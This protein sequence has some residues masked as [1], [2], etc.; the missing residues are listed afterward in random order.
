MGATAAGITLGVAASMTGTSLPR[1]LQLPDVSG[2]PSRVLVVM[3]VPYATD[4]LYHDWLTG[5]Q[6]DH[7]E[8][9]YLTAVSRQINQ[10]S[11]V[12]AIRFASAAASRAPGTLSSS[13][14]I[15][16]AEK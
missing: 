6:Q 11:T 2:M 7:P 15:L 5:L 16:V 8:F 13:Q 12:P 3:G 1:V 14:A 10:L 4:L 9:A